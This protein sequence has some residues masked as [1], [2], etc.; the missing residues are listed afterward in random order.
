MA[1]WKTLPT[2]SQLLPLVDSW[3]Q[4][5]VGA[6]LLAVEQELI[7]DFLSN[8]FGYQL[9]QMSV[10][11]TANLIQESRIQANIVC[12]PLANEEKIINQDNEVTP[13]AVSLFDELP[14]AEDSFDAVVLHHAQE[15]VAN[16][17]NVLREVERIVIPNGKIIIIGFNPWSLMGLYSSVAG[18][19]RKTMWRNHLLSKQRMIDWLNLLD[20]KIIETEAAFHRPPIKMAR[21]FDRIKINQ[22]KLWRSIPFGG[23]Y[24]ITAVKRVSA[25]TPQ[26]PNW[27]KKRAFAG[28]A[29]IKPTTRALR[30]NHKD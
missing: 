24:C 19:N 15:F 10:A 14:F 20:F 27:S 22:H 8:A 29:P 26:K 9:L 3:Y 17:H 23:V 6:R 1:H 4:S 18:I 5:E 30:K 16:P 13:Q 12:H 2:L 7:N 25:V 21:V 11:N 28:L